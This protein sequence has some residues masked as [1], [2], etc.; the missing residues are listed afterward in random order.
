M[1]RSSLGAKESVQNH[2]S[3]FQSILAAKFHFRKKNPK[4]AKK[5]PPK[6]QKL[7]NFQNFRCGLTAENGR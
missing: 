1:S 2:F 7:P 6:S 4:I 5:G 3:S